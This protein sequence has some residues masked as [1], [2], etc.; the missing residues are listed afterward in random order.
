MEQQTEASSARRRAEL[1]PWGGAGGAKRARGYDRGE[2]DEA[3]LA[4][5]TKCCL[6]ELEHHNET[7][8]PEAERSSRRAAPDRCR[9]RCS[10]RSHWRCCSPF[11][12]SIPLFSAPSASRPRTSARH[13]RVTAGSLG[14]PLQ[15]SASMRSSS[16]PGISAHY[17]ALA[18]AFINSAPPPPA[19][20]ASQ[21]ALSFTAPSFDPANPSSLINPAH[22][23]TRQLNG[24][25]THPPHE[26]GVA[27]SLN[28]PL[29]PGSADAGAIDAR[30]AFPLLACLSA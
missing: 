21:P 22:A 24:D 17:D 29:S 12:F 18:S 7:D 16:L 4:L 13:T 20:C 9:K 8:E 3:A 28:E 26:E 15:N 2:Q 23:S 30:C 19:L 10:R 25:S 11:T 6:E 14:H 27:H 1:H 5:L